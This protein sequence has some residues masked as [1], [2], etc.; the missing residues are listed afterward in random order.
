MNCL[1]AG[2][3]RF[4][5]AEF[6]GS[7]QPKPRYP[8]FVAP[9]KQEVEEAAVF[10]TFPSLFAGLVDGAGRVEYYDGRLRIV[11]PDGALLADGLDPTRYQDYL[12]EATEPWSYL[13]FP[14]Y[15]PYGY[16]D[17]AYRVGPLARL[18]VAT[19]C[20][21]PR[22]DAEL[23]EYRERTGRV[24]LSS[25]YYHYARLIEIVHA[26]EQIGRLLDDPAILDRNVRARAGRNRHVGIGVAEAPRGTL[27]HH[28]EVDDDGRLVRVNLL[29]ATG[30]NNLA[31]NR[32]VAQVAAHYIAGDEVR[33]GVLNRLEAAIRAF[34]PCLSCSTHA[35]GAMPLVVDVVGPDGRLV[36]RLRRDPPGAGR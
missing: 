14:Y 11:G 36:R 17:G 8:V 16:P 3:V 7:N 32:A 24:A 18:A 31:M 13:K 25:F 26:L 4:D 20:G 10:G 33:E 5:L 15:R 1:Y 9:L 21:T 22:A 34:D 2:G 12:G 23:A 30:Q 19:A 35:V 28:Y 6:F 29:I 27:Y